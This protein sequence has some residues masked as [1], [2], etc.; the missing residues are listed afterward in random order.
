[1]F[2]VVTLKRYIATELCDGNLKQLVRGEYRG[3]PIGSIDEIL[4]QIS[5]AVEYL[6]DK[7]IYHRDIKPSNVL[8]LRPD[9]TLGPQM[10]LSDFAFNRLSKK[11]SAARLYKLVGTKGWMAPEVYDS[12]TFTPEMDVFSLGLIFAYVISEGRH[13]FGESKEERIIN[14]KTRQLMAS[15]NIEQ[16]KEK[17]GT[18]GVKFISSMF[19]FK[20]EERP[21][22]GC[23]LNYIS[24]HQSTGGIIQ[25]SSNPPTAAASSQHGT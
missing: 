25:S 13:P 23:I 15:E 5:S 16:L 17:M 2:N 14:I 8:I 9:G 6:H 20:P 19:S 18:E 12:N 3:P 1:M 7:Y 21:T 4:R 10:K 11:P 24:L 22:A